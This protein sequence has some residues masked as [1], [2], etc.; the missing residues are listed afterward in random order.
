MEIF[1]PTLNYLLV[2]TRFF[3]R[4][5]TFFFLY[6]CSTLRFYFITTFDIWCIYAIYYDTNVQICSK[7]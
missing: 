5:S 7:I 2:F 6:V 3:G 1:L 4:F